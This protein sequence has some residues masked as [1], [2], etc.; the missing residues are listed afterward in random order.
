MN[1]RETLILKALQFKQLHTN[2]SSFGGDL[3]DAILA[4][5]S[6]QADEITKNVCARIPVELANEME[7]IGGLLNLNKREMITMALIDFLEKAKATIDEFD[8]FP[9]E[10]I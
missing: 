4:S 6:A 10:E 7:S 1:T 8:I 9:K 2:G 5:D 3:V